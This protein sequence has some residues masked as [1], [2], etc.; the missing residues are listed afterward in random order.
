Q[1]TPLTKRESPSAA[2]SC[3]QDEREH[4]VGQA[5]QQHDKNG[6]DGAR[7]SSNVVVMDS[8]ITWIKH[9]NSSAPS[10]E[11]GSSMMQPIEPA[12]EVVHIH[13]LQ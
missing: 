7:L 10:T 4:E 9:L 2:G 11:K 8:R 3:R 6:T 5:Q 12:R 13:T 1:T